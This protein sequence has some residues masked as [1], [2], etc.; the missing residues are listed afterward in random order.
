MRVNNYQESPI[1]Q[2]IP[3]S[4]TI[5][6]VDKIQIGLSKLVERLSPVLL[7]LIPQVDHAENKLRPHTTLL[8]EKLTACME[9][10]NNLHD[11]LQI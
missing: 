3:M 4:S 6:H 5:E 2:P 7:P 9:I 8:E 11:R 1:V 10:I